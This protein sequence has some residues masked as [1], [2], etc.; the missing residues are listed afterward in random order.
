MLYSYFSSIKKFFWSS[1][2]FHPININFRNIFKKQNI[3]SQ[4]SPFVQIVKL[5]SKFIGLNSSKPVFEDQ[6][7]FSEKKINYD[8]KVIHCP[9][10]VTRPQINDGYSAL[11]SGF[12][13]NTQDSLSTL[14]IHT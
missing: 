12:T 14:R 9:R 2:F 1:N 4:K 11:H 8:Q 10:P 5:E 3:I 7:T 6:G 13:F